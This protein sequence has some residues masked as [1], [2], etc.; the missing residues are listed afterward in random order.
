MDHATDVTLP[1]DMTF[2]YTTDSIQNRTFEFGTTIMD[3]PKTVIPLTI[4]STL[5]SVL[6]STIK[7]DTSTVPSSL[8]STSISS[9]SQTTVTSIEV[10]T[11]EIGACRGTQCSTNTTM[12]TPR[13]ITEV[14]D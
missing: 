2:R 6:S 13:N 8:M 12:I 4:S 10:N 11:T 5:P 7:L 9:L 1:I 14:S 3:T